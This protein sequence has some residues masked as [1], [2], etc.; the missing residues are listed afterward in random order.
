MIQLN[1]Q[2]NKSVVSQWL[3]TQG[4]HTPADG[5]RDFVNAM[6]DWYKGDVEKFHHYSVYNGVQFVGVQRYSLGMAKTIAHD[7]ADLLLNEKV[8]IGLGGTDDAWLREI[9]TRNNFR[10]NAN[11]LIE[12][13]FALGTGAL[14]EM[15]DSSG[16]AVIDYVFSDMIYPMTWRRQEIT[17]CAFASQVSSAGTSKQQFYIQRHVLD[18]RTGTYHIFNN[19]IDEDGKDLPIPE[20]ILPEVDTHSTVPTFQIIR[21]NIVN[22]HDLYNPMGISVYGTAIDSL[23][24]CDVVYDAYMNE[25]DRGRTR[26]MIPTS[27]AKLEMTK[28]GTAHLAFDSRDTIFYA[29]ETNSKDMKVEC[30]QPEIRAEQFKTGIRDAINI[31]SMRCGLG[32]NRYSFDGHGVRTATE[33]YSEDSDLYQSVCKHEILLRAALIGMVRALGQI[34]GHGDFPDT[35]IDFDDSIIDDP[36]TRIDRH[37][38]TVNAGLESK[39]TAI[40]EI[41]GCTEEE[42][43]IEYKRIQEENMITGTPDDWFGGDG[44]DGAAEKTAGAADH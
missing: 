43:E 13:S 22:T 10:V 29:Y 23:R 39:R 14:V 9:L 16:N 44:D 7:Y 11:N 26:L 33:V 20:G 3:E 15:L 30:F 21:P 37:V 12:L 8:Q 5:Y 18:K 40:R 27:M 32:N 34:T 4:I 42:A 28:D 25:F 31:L 36:D 38:K 41:R 35:T 19:Y 2:K 1:E 6:M 17:E 24:G